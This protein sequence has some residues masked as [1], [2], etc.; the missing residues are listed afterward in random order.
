MVIESMRSVLIVLLAI[1]ISLSI[2]PV[3]LS[4]SQEQIV[5]EMNII[6]IDEYVYADVRVSNYMILREN[7][8][9]FFGFSDLDGLE[10]IFVFQSNWESSYQYF[11]DL[12][13]S[14]L[15]LVDFPKTQ[16][17]VKVDD[18]MER[19]DQ[20][21]SILES[22][23]RTKL[24]K[25]GDKL[26]G[27]VDQTIFL[28]FLSDILPQENLT[29]FLNWLNPF[30]LFN[31]VDI[32]AFYIN[33]DNGTAVF[34]QYMFRTIP[35]SEN[36]IRLSGILAT[37]A[38]YNPQEGVISTL[39][40]RLYSGYVYETPENVSFQYDPNE[41]FYEITIENFDNVPPPSQFIIG[42]YRSTPI[43][44]FHRY[45]NT[46]VFNIGGY[47]EVVLNVTVPET[48]PSIFNLT[49]Q[50]VNWWEGVG[51]LVEGDVNQTI[52]AL[53]SGETELI[54]YVVRIDSD[55][56]LD[57]Y[58]PPAIASLSF[59]GGKNVTVYSNDY[60][61]HLNRDAP[62]LVVEI[63]PTSNSIEVGRDYEFVAKISNVGSSNAE[64]VVFSD[65]LIGS[66]EPNRV[67]RVNESIL[68]FDE[69]AFSSALSVEADYRY[70]DEEY[71]VRSMSVSL[72]PIRSVYF[73]YE[74][75]G[76]ITSSEINESAVTYS[77]VLENNGPR[78]LRDVAIYIRLFSEV[79]FEVSEDYAYNGTHIIIELDVLDNED[80]YSIQVNV[81]YPGLVVT[82]RPQVWFYVYSDLAFSLDIDY[83]YNVLNIEVNGYDA[84]LIKEKP[85]EFTIEF[86]NNG[87]IPVYNISMAWTRNVEEVVLL[88]E[89][90]IAPQLSPGS[91]EVVSVNL[92]A[93]ETGEIEM[94]SARF[95]YVYLGKS[96]SS[97]VEF[98]AL[99]VFSGISLELNR[100]DLILKSGE[101]VNIV[102]TMDVDNESLY[103]D[104]QLRL[105][106][107]DGLSLV[108]QTID[109]YITIEGGIPESIVITLR[110]E[111]PGPYEIDT[112]EVRYL[113]NDR[114][115]EETLSV[116]LVVRVREDVTST[117]MVWLAPGL[118]IAILFS[119]LIRKR[120]V[121]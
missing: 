63:I 30:A 69:S 25:M 34:Q 29:S 45:F 100:R 84:I 10:V 80:P 74:I 104:L 28:S 51:E 15:G 1:V 91:V 33:I 53:G 24:V 98:D 76:W 103:S 26:V 42:V 8:E 97:I 115:I 106:L 44:L 13:V 60:Y 11:L 40:M 23:F 7:M 68:L 43:F 17:W 120:I 105:L 6:V 87:P 117:Y 35:I 39:S 92:T 67:I 27:S 73:K 118:V 12:N 22:S 54:S 108:N 107:P 71:K 66:L 94:P 64:N 116:Q 113:F 14:L 32:Q 37:S 57:V 102:L 36:R 75:T 47:V 41:D 21:I 121:G 111:R 49:I 5:E 55:E 88:P 59:I 20:V 62:L 31:L 65:F 16:L 114:V 89:E 61:I 58:I 56:L 110:G 99:N 72:S 18:R 38:P 3:N 95:T 2:V 70:E 96:R 46:S 90:Y 83:F 101:T 93:L 48:S 112:I 86:I 109:D 77:I 81:T 4:Y 119:I 19:S 52:D 82:L 9:A 79:G 50:E 78:P 85:E